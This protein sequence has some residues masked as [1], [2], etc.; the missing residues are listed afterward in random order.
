MLDG[1]GVP[2]HSVDFCFSL[3]DAGVSGLAD[4]CSHGMFFT[5]AFK[6]VRDQVGFSVRWL[7]GFRVVGGVFV[8]GLDLLW[9]SRLC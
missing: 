3:E 7:F 6:M 2:E 1:K 9:Y 4:L 8:V 5:L